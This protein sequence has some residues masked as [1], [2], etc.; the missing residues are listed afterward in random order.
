MTPKNKKV[1]EALTLYREHRANIKT[2]DILLWSGKGFCSTV[3]KKATKSPYSHTGIVLRSRYE[4]VL[5]VFESTAISPLKSG[6]QL[7]LLSDR[8]LQA[9]KSEVFVR[10]L[11]KK[12]SLKQQD[13]LWANRSKWEGVRYES[14]VTD[15]ALAGFG[16]FRENDTGDLAI[17]CSELNK[18]N[19]ESIGLLEYQ[20]KFHSPVDYSSMREL[21]L[22]KGYSY[23]EE[24]KIK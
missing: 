18:L 3:I 9:G 16:W 20:H 8:L 12:L 11:D 15:L 19:L 10:H 23:G 1:Q 7:N 2:G 17:Y 6:V 13:T 4:G 24:I 22:T 5:F 14:S 21:P